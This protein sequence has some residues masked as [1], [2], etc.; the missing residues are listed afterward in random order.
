MVIVNLAHVHL[1][2][3]YLSCRR[4]LG[5]DWPTTRRM[6]H[7]CH[8]LISDF[9][10][11]KKPPL[12][13]FLVSGWQAASDGLQCAALHC[14]GKLWGD[15]E[16][17][18]QWACFGKEEVS[19]PGTFHA[20]WQRH[21]VIRFRLSLFVKVVCFFHLQEYVEYYGGPGVQHIA[22]N[23][24]DI[25]TAA[26]TKNSFL[27]FFCFCKCTQ[28]AAEVKTCIM[29]QTA[30]S[31]PERTRDGVHVCARHL[32]RPAE[33]ESKTVKAQN[34]RGPRRS[35]GQDRGPSQNVVFLSS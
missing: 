31:K 29:F 13:P 8:S 5:D 9:Q 18:H 25:I 4:L 27:W 35:T 7:C 23:T 30:D 33:G 32:L 16:N 12:S 14:G 24:S 15:G 19:D 2:V 11:S 10:V 21:E 22:M 26:S 17:A 3:K 6:T 1:F 28:K 34:L 20:F